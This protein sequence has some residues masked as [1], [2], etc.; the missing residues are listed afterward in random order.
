MISLVKG[1]GN[2]LKKTDKL[3]WLLVLAVTGYGLFTIIFVSQ[4]FGVKGLTTQYAATAIGIVACL[5]VSKIDYNDLASLWKLYAPAA[6]LFV[7]ALFIWGVGGVGKEAADDKNWLI[8][9]GVSIQPTEILKIT[10]IMEFAYHLSWVGEDLNQP[11]H[12]ILLALHA[13][14]PVF[15]IYLLGDD[16]TA[17][18]FVLI[19]V[20]MVIIAGLAWQYILAGAGALVVMIP[21]AWNFLLED[22]HKKRFLAVWGNISDEKGSQWQQLRSIVSIGSGQ[23]TGVG[24]HA[25]KYMQF[26][27]IYNDFIFSFVGQ[28]FGFVGCLLLISLIVALCIKILSVSRFSTNNLG[29]HICVGIFAMIICQSIINIGMCLMLS[30]VVGI[31]LPFFSKGGSSIISVYICIG[32]V[33]SVYMH[34][35]VGL[36][37]TRR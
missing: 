28:V 9:F 21:V 35:G 13:I 19:A 1:I 20:I 36:F 37:E 31:T 4:K 24:I 30:P 11:A 8:I 14:T 34:S 32:L 25:E 16:G 18:V 2:Y 26:D 29:V 7:L 15:I 10:F 23:I 27:E 3:L 6:Y 33:L 17:L 12:L 5:I 22:H